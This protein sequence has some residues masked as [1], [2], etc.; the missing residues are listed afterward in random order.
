[1]RLSR[2]AL[3][4]C[5]V[6]TLMVW[7]RPAEARWA[8]SR[9]ILHGTAYTLEQG[10]FVLGLLSPLSY[11][12]KNSVTI[13]THPVMWLLLTPNG[14]VRWRVHDNDTLAVA[15]TFDGAREF[16]LEGAPANKDPR[17][18]G[19]LSTGLSLSFDL[20]DR[21][22]FTLSGGYSR[23]FGPDENN[24]SMGA[25]IAVLISSA[26]LLL[27]QGNG[28]YEPEDGRFHSVTGSLIYAHAWENLRAGVGLA[29]GRFPIVL[30]KDGEDKA[31]DVPVWPVLDLW[32]RY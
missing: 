18:E 24:L 25:G 8:G 22:A 6:V 16:G 4:T 13:T 17:P 10:E 19:S 1:M 12:A 2:Y 23:H 29:Y 3:L 11:G 26:R 31:M 30:E 7:N 28:L 14:G 15:L 20:F 27:L 5:A 21:L 9:T 32:W